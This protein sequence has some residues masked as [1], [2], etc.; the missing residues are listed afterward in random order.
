VPAKPDILPQLRELAEKWEGEACTAVTHANAF[1]ISH[2]TPNFRSYAALA[3]ALVTCSLELL[4]VIES[5]PTPKQATPTEQWRPV[6]ETEPKED[7]EVLVCGSISFPGACML[8]Y[9]ASNRWWAQGND[10]EDY[11]I[12]CPT[13]WLPIPPP[14]QSLPPS[15]KPS[16]GIGSPKKE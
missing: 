12:A 9:R 3:S 14:P 16:I 7:D 10:A 1:R 13:L 11:Q 15:F 2:D 6:T 8:A 5:T 4:K